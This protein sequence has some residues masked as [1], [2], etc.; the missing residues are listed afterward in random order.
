M[1]GGVGVWIGKGAGKTLQ[2]WVGH[3]WGANSRGDLESEKWPGVRRGVARNLPALGLPELRLWSRIGASNGA[4]GAGV[5]P[6]RP[7][8]AEFWAT[9]T[10]DFGPVLQT[11][12]TDPH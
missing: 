12:L 10:S 1:W 6:M 5:H 3:A 4:G 8:P 2:M 11:P 9:P 7:I